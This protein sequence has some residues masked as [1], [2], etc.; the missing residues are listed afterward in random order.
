LKPYDVIAIDCGGVLHITDFRVDDEE[1]NNRDIAVDEMK[2]LEPLL[3][4]L[5][6]EHILVLVCNSTKKKIFDLFRRSG[7]GKY[8]DKMYIAPNK[9]P[10]VPR[11][12]KVMRDYRTEKIILLDDKT[13]N[14]DDARMNDIPALQ[15]TYD[16]L[17]LFSK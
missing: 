6:R 17:I 9:S 2:S 4:R 5:S 14:I 16:D 11:L 1:K 12:E 3:Q 13:R 10:K 8:F 7:L 15:I